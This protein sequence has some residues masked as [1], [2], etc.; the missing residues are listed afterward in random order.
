L[1]GILLPGFCHMLTG[2]TLA[3]FFGRRQLKI[4]RRAVL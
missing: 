1:I 2:G 4:Q 3:K